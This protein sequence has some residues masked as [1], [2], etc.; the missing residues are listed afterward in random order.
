ML[1]CVYANETVP[2]THVLVCLKIQR[3]TW[4]PGRW[5]K[6]R[7]AVNF[8]KSRNISYVFE[9]VEA[10]DLRMTLNSTHDQLHINRG[11]IR[12]VIPEDLWKS[13]ICAKFVSQSHGWPWRVNQ[14]LTL[15]TRSHASRLPLVRKVKASSNVT[16]EEAC[17]P[18]SMICTRGCNYIFMYSWW[19]ARW[20]PETCRVI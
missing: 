16:F 2:H 14:T 9:P 11:T 12:Q 20:T 17:S 13:V 19:W 7:A 5:F 6:Q 3:R 15:L 18:D 4:R 1:R 10:R 8:L